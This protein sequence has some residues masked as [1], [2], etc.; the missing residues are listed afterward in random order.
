MNT[1]VSRVSILFALVL[2]CSCG[3]THTIMVG[4]ARAATTPDAIRVYSS[5]PRQYERIAIINSSSGPTWAFTTHGQLDDAITKL[6]EEAAKVGAN[7]IL[8]EATGTSSG[9]N[10]GLGIGGFGAGGGPHSG[11]SVSGEG[12]FSAPILHK[13]AQ[14]TAIYVQ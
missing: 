1:V 9:S 13:T 10:L 11:Y 4:P 8:I 2:L 7:G 3:S 12:G 14:A 6:K 5:P